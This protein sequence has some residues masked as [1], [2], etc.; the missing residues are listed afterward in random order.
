MHL[1]W[2]YF[3]LCKANF[4]KV[5]FKNEWT[6]VEESQ[7]KPPNI[8]LSRSSQMQRIH[9][10]WLHLMKFKGRWRWSTGIESRK[11]VGMGHVGT[12]W[13]DG[14]VLYLVWEWSLQACVHVL[15]LL[16]LLKYVF[17]T[18]LIF[19]LHVVLLKKAHIIK[20]NNRHILHTWDWVI[21]ARWFF[22]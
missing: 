22:S 2:G 6:P 10:I 11:G 9:I 7:R 12:L 19:C 15:K 21:F 20:N 14:Q 3:I 16:I 5:D 1:K 4:N 8:M 18:V 17:F 13:G